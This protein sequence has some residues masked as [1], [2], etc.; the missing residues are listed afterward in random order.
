MRAAIEIRPGSRGW[1]SGTWHA[2]PSAVVLPPP[3]AAGIR[4]GRPRSRREPGCRRRAVVE[5]QH[6]RQAGLEAV[7]VVDHPGTGQAQ[8]HEVAGPIEHPIRG[9]DPPVDVEEVDE[10][11][12]L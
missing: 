3:P 1:Y 4:A 12:V 11:A 9:L 8:G 2:S 7:T 10:Q 5:R 6:L